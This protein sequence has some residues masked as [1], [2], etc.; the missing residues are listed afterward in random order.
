MKELLEIVYESVEN[1]FDERIEE[2]RPQIVTAVMAWLATEARV[3]PVA[4]LAARTAALQKRVESLVESMKVRL[5][6]GKLVV[7]VNGSDE[8]TLKM[9]RLGTT[10]FEPHP[11]PNELFLTGFFD[12]L[13]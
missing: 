1:E 12:E 5:V 6:D 13:T 2:R 11:Y 3:K 7:K 9:F 10:W 8:E 4:D